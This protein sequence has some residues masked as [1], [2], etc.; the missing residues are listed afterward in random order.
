[1]LLACEYLPVC[2]FA[3]AHP[4]DHCCAVVKLVTLFACFVAARTC[5]GMPCRS[6]PCGLECCALPV[7][8]RE[9]SDQRRC[10]EVV[11]AL[12]APYCCCAV[13]LSRAVLR[14]YIVVC[15]C[16]AKPQNLSTRPVRYA[17]TIQSS[18]TPPAPSNCFDAAKLNELCTCLALERC[19]L[20]GLAGCVSPRPH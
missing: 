19:E 16:C 18:H 4:A 11:L 14:V 5:L 17:E 15:M 20:G 3:L 7:N 13:I 10:L 1:M 8:V 2:T 9:Q 6:R 12:P